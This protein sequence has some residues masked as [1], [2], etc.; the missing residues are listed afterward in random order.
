MRTIEDAHFVH[1]LFWQFCLPRQ[2]LCHDASVIEVIAYDDDIEILVSDDNG[3]LVGLGWRRTG[4][5]VIDTYSLRALVPVLDA[6]GHHA[7]GCFVERFLRKHGLIDRHG[8]ITRRCRMTDL[9]RRRKCYAALS[10]HLDRDLNSDDLRAVGPVPFSDDVKAYVRIAAA[11]IVD[12][13]RTLA[14]HALGGHP[15]TH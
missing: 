3:V 12:W 14:T 7:L 15:R 13:Q 9:D 6:L 1:R 11:H 8:R 4:S 5:R 10:K 2:V